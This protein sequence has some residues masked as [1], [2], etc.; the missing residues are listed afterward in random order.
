MSLTCVPLCS[1]DAGN[2]HQGASGQLAASAG[3][4]RCHPATSGKCADMAPTAGGLAKSCTRFQAPALS[5]ACHHRSGQRPTSPTA[6]PAVRAR[7]RHR[8]ASRGRRRWSARPAR[9]LLR[10]QRPTARSAQT[11]GLTSI[12][13]PPPPSTP[14]PGQAWPTPSSLPHRP[15]GTG[16]RLS[17]RPS[18]WVS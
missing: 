10:C 7:S 14:P 4:P 3:W 17:V 8:S 11:E 9:A 13:L 16:C 12:P 2:P 6:S 18:R 5:P 1:L 15:M